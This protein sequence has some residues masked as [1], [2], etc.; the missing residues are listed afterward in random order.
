[1]QIDQGV[2]LE[3]LS[4]VAHGLGEVVG[5]GLRNLAN[6][7][8]EMNLMPESTLRWQSFNQKKPYFAFTVISL[9]LV[10]F[11]IGFLFDKI[12]ANK[13]K[14]AA[15]LSPKI[16]EIQHKSDRFDAVYRKLLK[17]RADAQQITGL[18]Q[19]RFYWCDFM[20]DMRLALIRSE[21]SV[22]K[23]LSVQKPGVESGIW[24]EQMIS[25]PNL[26]GASTTGPN[27]APPGTQQTQ[28]GMVSTNSAIVFTCRAVDLKN[29]DAAADTQIAYTVES[30]IKNS[31]LVDPKATALVGSIVPDDSNGTFTFTIN[32]APANSL[33]F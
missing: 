14:A 11:A 17:S 23:K 18:L 8:V 24:I 2:N 10:L 26:M 15:D 3:E 22:K 32:V 9:V 19:D 7:P 16:D 12:A 31:P 27:G 29:V 21:I 33:N 4:R 28:P 25:A 13:E 1:V 5:L 6:C 20:A 30:E